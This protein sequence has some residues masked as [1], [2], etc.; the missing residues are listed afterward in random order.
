VHLA[1]DIN[2]ERVYPI[3]DEVVN[4]ITAGSGDSLLFQIMRE[5]K[6]MV[7]EIES[8]IEETGAYR[9]L[10]IRYDVRQA[11]LEES[12]REVFRL[13]KRLCMYIRPVRMELSRMQFTDNL[14]FYED[15][16]AGMVEMMG[17]AWMSGDLA[18]C[19]LEA[20]ASLYN[21]LTVEDLQNSA[22]DIFR[23]ENLTASVRYDPQECTADIPSLLQE[24][25]K[26]L[27]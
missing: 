12:L 20:E 26:T 3:T 19:D 6:A 18:R 16:P 11:M 10:V 14:A 22:Q 13:L 2:A 25:R 1:F 21:D 8:Y 24:L 7:A 17:W 9:R 4:A 15:D 23:A 5:E 27:E